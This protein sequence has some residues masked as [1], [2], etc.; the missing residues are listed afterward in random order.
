[1]TTGAFLPLF[2]NMKTLFE[3]DW[4]WI[5]PTKETFA[6]HTQVVDTISPDAA[7]TGARGFVF[8]DGRVAMAH[9]YAGDWQLPGGGVEI[10]ETGKEAFVREVE[11][12]TGITK[13]ANIS[14]LCFRISTKTDEKGNTSED[15]DSFFV[16]TAPALPAFVSDPAG[17]IVET[18]LVD[19][20]DVAQYLGWLP[21]ES[22]NQLVDLV[23]KQ[24]K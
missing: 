11:E 21:I 15:I 2:S 1:L 20:C 22:A 4:T 24:Q 5:H 8:V 7:L 6:V 19:L 12:E 9:S 17:T 16:A 14:Q 3:Y 23:K 13:L 18:A 10:G